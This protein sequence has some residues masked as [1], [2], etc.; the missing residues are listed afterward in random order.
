MKKRLGILLLCLMVV[1]SLVGCGTNTSQEAVDVDS[2]EVEVGESY[3]LKFGMVAGTQSNEY[4]AVQKL[5]EEVKEKS[6]GRLT[7][8]I[9]PESQLG[10]DRAM[11]EQ[12][13]GGALDLTLA[14]TGRFGIWVPRAEILGASYIVDSFEHLQRVIYETD[15]GKELHEELINKHNWRVI[16]T[17]YNGT[18]Q[19]SSNRAINSIDD[20]KGLKIRVPNHQPLLEYAEFVG[21]T[22]TPMAFTEVYLALQTNA[23]DAQENP[24]ST[25]KAVKF[26]EV[27]DYLAITNH[28]IND[29]NYIVSEHTWNKLPNDLQA[30]LKDATVEAAVY[31]TS[32]FVNEEKELIEYFEGEGVTVTK[33][34]LAPFKEAVAKSYQRYIDDIGDEAQKVLDAIESVR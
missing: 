30:I 15:F 25:I 3:V 26:Y 17:G 8:E 5:V 12:L 2:G 23:V 27:Q 10:D 34:D 11:L 14:E 4:K 9:F 22:P 7:I 33:P 16:G 24:L 29:V 6:D 13:E 1:L 32:L 31:H 28:T 19:T 21:A 20:M 18:R